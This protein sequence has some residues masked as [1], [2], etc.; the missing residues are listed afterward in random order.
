M[1]KLLLVV[2]FVV[3]GVFGF[4]APASAAGQV[5]IEGYVNGTPLPV[6]GCTAL[7]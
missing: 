3:A 6:N 2:A 4:A 5:C 1:K 7:P